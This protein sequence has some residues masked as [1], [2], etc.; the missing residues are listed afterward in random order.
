[1]VRDY[2]S[3]IISL[4][5]AGL[6]VLTALTLLGIALVNS[7]LH[8]AEMLVSSDKETPQAL[9]PLRGQ[10]SPPNVP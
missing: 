2:L 10:R 7:A 1:M 3:L 8:G 5:L 4:G 6:G 9:Q